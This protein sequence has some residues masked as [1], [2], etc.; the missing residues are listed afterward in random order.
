M[1]VKQIDAFTF[2]LTLLSA[3]IDYGLYHTLSLA[4]PGFT[5]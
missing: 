3:F 1:A 5:A 4:F 2:I